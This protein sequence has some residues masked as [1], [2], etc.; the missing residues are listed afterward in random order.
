[1]YKSNERPVVFWNSRGTFRWLDVSPRLPAGHRSEGVASD[2]Y[3]IIR[4]FHRLLFR[5]PMP[6]TRAGGS[7]TGDFAAARCR[8]SDNGASR[9]HLCGASED[10]L[11][12]ALART[13]S[14]GDRDDHGNARGVHALHETDAEARIQHRATVQDGNDLEAARDHQGSD[15]LHAKADFLGRS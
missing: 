4:C 7:E 3:R 14:A 1:L 8:A 2:A 6:G 9:M 10:D 15:F 12:S 13:R 5:Y 11:R